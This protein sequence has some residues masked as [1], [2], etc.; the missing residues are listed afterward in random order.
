M[1]FAPSSVQGLSLNFPTYASHHPAG[2]LSA[3]ARALEP[4]SQG[5]QQQALSED[6][7]DAQVLGYTLPV[8]PD[9]A[10]VAGLF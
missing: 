1:P 9:L 5:P 7:A 2:P 10:S 6:Q 4:A 8:G 3:G